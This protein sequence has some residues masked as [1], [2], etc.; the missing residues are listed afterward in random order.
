MPRRKVVGVRG[1]LLRQMWMRNSQRQKRG[2]GTDWRKLSQIINFFS[3]DSWLST[4]T[5]IFLCWV[6]Q[7]DFISATHGVTT[8][9]I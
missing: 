5:A 1:Q 7:D 4:Y 9:V 8:M 3:E 2:H 6:R